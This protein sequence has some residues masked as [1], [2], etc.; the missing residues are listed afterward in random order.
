MVLIFHLYFFRP[1]LWL[2]GSYRAREMF[3]G[4]TQAAILAVIVILAQTTKR[5]HGDDTAAD[6]S[7][8]L[9]LTKDTFDEAVKANK[10]LLVKF[11]APW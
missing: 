5:A 10:Y 3:P 9:T 8:V 6:D 2:F 7:D 4:F 1:L 11:V